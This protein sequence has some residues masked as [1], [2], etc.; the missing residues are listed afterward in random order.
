MRIYVRMIFSNESCMLASIDADIR[1]T[2]TTLNYF[3]SIPEFS[4]RVVVRFIFSD[5]SHSIPQNVLTR[6]VDFE[7]SSFFFF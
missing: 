1:C 2:K 3:V 6:D 7:K 4:V 5:L